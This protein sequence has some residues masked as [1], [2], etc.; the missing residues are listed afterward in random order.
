[1][2][3]ESNYSLSFLDIAILLNLMAVFKLLCSENRFSQVSVPAFLAFVRFDL[4]LNG[5]QTLLHRGFRICSTYYALHAEFEFV[6]N[7]FLLDGFPTNLVFTQV[8]KFMSKRYNELKA[9]SQS[10]AKSESKVFATIV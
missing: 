1:M 5:L 3:L 8:K 10:A 2:E 7:I 4:R 6:R 9:R